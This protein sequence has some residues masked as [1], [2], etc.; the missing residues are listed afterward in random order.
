MEDQN[1]GIGRKVAKHF[2]LNS[3][4]SFLPTFKPLY[5]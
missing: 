2:K 5:L 3:S 1:P 4:N